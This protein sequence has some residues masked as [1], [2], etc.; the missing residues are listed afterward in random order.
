[1]SA[2]STAAGIV[3]GESEVLTLTDQVSTHGN[4]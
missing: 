2:A 3:P 4:D 1:M